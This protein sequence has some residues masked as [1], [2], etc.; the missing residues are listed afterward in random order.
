MSMENGKKFLE[1]LRSNEKAL[2]KLKELGTPTGET[3]EIREVAAIARETGYD[4]TDEELE[5]LVKAAKKNR[6]T[7]SDKAAETVEKLDPEDL[8][9]AAG[10]D[11][12]NLADG[13]CW[14]ESI[15]LN[16][17]D[18]AEAFNTCSKYN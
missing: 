10:G 5:K 7:A 2:A 1:E 6:A 9:T 17:C 11:E 13:D 4:V 8:D 15:L 12:P 18:N 16:L 14:Y 3:E